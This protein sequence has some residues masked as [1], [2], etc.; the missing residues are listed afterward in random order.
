MLTKKAILTVVTSLILMGG[1]SAPYVAEAQ[2]LSSGSSSSVT[3]TNNPPIVS[4][5]SDL[6]EPEEPK[7]IIQQGDRISSAESRCTLGYAN[8]NYGITS[9][10]CFDIGTSIFHNRVHIGTVVDAGYEGY[11]AD[12]DWAV[13]KFDDNVKVLDNSY[14]G[15]NIVSTSE[16]EI[17]DEACTYGVNTDKIQCGKILFLRG[18]IVYTETINTM[19]GDSG[20]PVWVEEKGLIGMHKG[21]RYEPG[22]LYEWNVLGALPDHIINK[23]LA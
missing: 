23:I 5:P 6:D 20:G 17:G 21:T 10:H 11:S 18:H 4:V 1:V 22:T 19:G 8:D 7:A 12:K 9:G 3:N 2:S 16:L 15:D 14:S 13:I